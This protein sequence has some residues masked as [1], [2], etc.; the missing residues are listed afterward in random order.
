MLGDRSAVICRKI[1]EVICYGDTVTSPTFVIDDKN[2]KQY[3]DLVMVLYSTERKFLDSRRSEGIA[4]S[5]KKG[6]YKGRKKARIDKLAA[7]EIFLDYAIKK[8]AVKKRPK[9]L[10]SVNQHF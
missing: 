3:F 4:A 7:Q 8:S 10:E 5:A 6:N 9:S 2:R 1:L